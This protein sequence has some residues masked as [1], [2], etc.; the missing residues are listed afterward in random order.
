LRV[1][2][3]RIAHAGTFLLGLGLGSVAFLGGCGGES[4]QTGTQVKVS[5][6]EK[7][8]LDDMRSANKAY[9]STQKTP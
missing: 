3:A 1:R 5:E 4:T 7:K 8:E 6:Q 9:Q 2:I